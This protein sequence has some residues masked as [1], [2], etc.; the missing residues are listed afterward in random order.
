[1]DES[2]KETQRKK[3]YCSVS[4]L[5]EELDALRKKVEESSTKEEILR[6]LEERLSKPEN[7]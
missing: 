6:Y 3:T 4:D 7:R 2:R 5:Q 1:M